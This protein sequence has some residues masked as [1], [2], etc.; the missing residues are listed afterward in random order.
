VI[1]VIRDIADRKRIQKDKYFLA[2]IVESLE[3]S[4]VSVDFDAIITSWNKG[5]ERVYGYRAEDIIGLKMRTGVSLASRPSRATS[6]S[7]REWM[8]L[9]ARVWSENMR[10]GPR[11]NGRTA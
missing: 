3:D 2:A 7:V 4:V 6:P 10:R 11:L 9:C 5:A 8:K 1:C